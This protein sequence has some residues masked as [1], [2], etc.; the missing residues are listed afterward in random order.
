MFQLLHTLVSGDPFMPHGHCY[1]W[2]PALLWMQVGSDMLIGASYVAIA[3][4]LWSMVQKGKT[5]IPF[6]PMFFAFGLFI[7]ACAGT[8]FMEVLTTWN[9][10]YWASGLVK[11][12]TAGASVATAFALPKVIPTALGMLEA[13]HISE[14]RRVQLETA[15][16]ELAE[17]NARLK[18]FDE[19]KTRFFANVSHELRT[20]LTLIIGPAQRLL[21]EPS[22]V[23]AER[24]SLEVVER[25]ARTLLKR[26]NDLL[27][28]ARLDA[29]RLA[30]HY[31]ETDLAGVARL[32]AR[33][34]DAVAAERGIRLAIETP[35]SMPAQGDTEKL[36]RVFINLLSNAFKFAPD[37]GVV[38]LALWEESAATRS[39]VLTVSDNGPGIP[40]AYRDMVFDRFGQPD[41]VAYRRT[42][43][44]GL[45]LAIVRE[46]V[47]MHGGEVTVGDAP[48]GGA[49]FTVR[50]P[51]SAPPGASIYPA[52][53]LDSGALDTA[54]AELRPPPAQRIVTSDRPTVLVV[55]DNPEVRS[56]IADGLSD[57][58]HVETAADG[59]EGLERAVALR[60]DLI[61]SDVMMPRKG[62]DELLRNVRALPLLAE[63]PVLLITARA[64]DEMRARLLGE[65]AQDYVTKPFTPAE[66]RARVVNLVA[67]KRAREALQEE[68]TVQGQDLESLVTEVGV[69]RREQR[70]ALEALRSALDGAE[71]A[72]RVKS[73]FLRMVSHE[74]R[75]P[76][77]AMQL[78]I[79]LLQR[80]SDADLAPRQREIVG[81][82]AAT[83]ARL[84]SLIES[85]LE[86][87]RIESGQAV[88]RV[89]EIDL[90]REATAVVE[91][92][93][94]QAEAKGVGLQLAL[95]DELPTLRTDPRLT[96]LIL[97]NLV[98]NA[99]KFTDHGHVAV[100]LSH[101]D[102][103][104]VITVTDT[105]PGIA[106]DR[107]TQVFEP[108][109]H[110]EPVRNKHT[111]GVGLGLT[112]VREM[113]EAMRGHIHL[114]SREDEGCI[115]TVS[116]PPLERPAPE[117]NITV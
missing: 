72:S 113:V 60:P 6:R 91:E 64:D 40:E 102:G 88:T 19:V 92:W 82:M 14:K 62:G 86:H 17:M 84:L 97:A 57:D 46:F 94:P 112:L 18:E 26:V 108:F 105:G 85:L 61:V 31:E 3:L 44:S 114:E 101:T 50:L 20:P 77:N 66:L 8:H 76:L 7:I 47:A 100:S 89:E 36:E 69:R 51:I 55:E 71:Q 87:S 110:L 15:N 115:F 79:Q 4:M 63:T 29:G 38:R 28:V 24:R 39:A 5:L 52:S 11:V 25:N 16:A 83:S 21:R 65:G 68:L 27:D 58:F 56:L 67:V 45:G 106:E 90:A 98:G 80:S 99:V 10:V 93:R 54:L 95:P 43:G 49:L 103:R 12:V 48:E 74:L 33:H 1:L 78:Q 22:L 13:A 41:P 23:P 2:T 42:Q 116:L 96:H 107:Q 81:K 104:H 30:I 53:G 111:P 73:S 70:A 59:E 34:F 32:T 9:P 75:N 109:E 35:D 117:G 37:D